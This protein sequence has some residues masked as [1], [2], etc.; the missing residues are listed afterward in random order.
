[1]NQPILL[2]LD[3]VL[4]TERCRYC[5]MCRHVCPVA[6][7]TRSEVT[8]PHG[9]GLLMASVR[10][11]LT[12][13]NPETVAILYHCADCGL[14]R[15]HCVTDQPL[16]L[17]INAGRA[18]VVEQ[19][20]APAVVYDLRDKFQ[21]WGN[22]Y[23]EA[24]P[25]KVTGRAETAL[26]VGAVAYHFQRST[27][28]AAQKLLAAA[29]VEV[30]PIALGRESPY[31]AST[32]GLLDE[33]RQLGQATLAEIAAVGAKRVLVLSPGDMYS[34]QT[35]LE[36][37][38]LGWPPGV[39]LVEVSTF[40]ARQLE[41]G[42]LTF[43]PTQASAY[44]FFDPDHTVRVPGRWQAPRQLLAAVMATPPLELFWSQDRAAPSGAHSGLYFTQPHLS[45]L[46]A[47]TRLAEAAE[48]GVRTLFT[49][50]PRVLHHLQR[51]AEKR[52]GGVVVKGLFELLAA[53][54]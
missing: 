15:A 49:D 5:L 10:R 14:C 7:V 54:L 41:A 26:L 34:F 38:G 36:A 6:Y 3:S 20:L 24:A 4:T 12:V 48:R 23:V 32:V 17:A 46:L 37:L 13:W 53:Q 11:G 51:Q 19:Q 47:Q 50:D 33:A 16:P 25:E 22:P 40:L 39:E 21:K 45:T 28:E 18:E 52:G 27:V 29:G 43:R 42:Q 31:M 8:S 35:L 44:A 9:W 1:M 2:H 30:A